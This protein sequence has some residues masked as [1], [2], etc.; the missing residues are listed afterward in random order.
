MT[1]VVLISRDY[2][3]SHLAPAIRHAAP[4]LRV[5][6]YGNEGTEDAE[7]AVC[8][9][10]PVGALA[11]LSRLRLIHSMAAGVDNIIADPDLPEVPVC[12]VVDP[13]HAQGMSEFV[14]WG[15][16]HYLRQL[17]VVLANQPLEIWYRPEQRKAADCSVGIMGLGEIGRRVALDLRRI[18]FAVRGWARSQREL[19]GIDVFHGNDGFRPF[20]E[21]TDILVCLLPL[22]GDTRG[23]LNRQTLGML[24]RGARLIH[25]GRGEHLIAEDV[26]AALDDGQ[27]SGAILDVAPQEPL[28]K[29]SALWRA[30]NVIITPHMASVASAETIGAQVA[31]NVRQLMRRESLFNV[32]D[33]RRGY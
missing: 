17:D 27:L 30:P 14:T 5:L 20:L 31:A 33:V 22:T 12:R 16:L 25:V 24:P 32:V 26:L 18:G 13:G 6:M 7:V 10:P 3:M 9:N 29:G 2:D 28:P 19:P 23:I 11:G 8:W 15:A 4:E 1:T 21:A